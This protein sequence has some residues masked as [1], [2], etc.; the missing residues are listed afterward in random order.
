MLEED[1]L[2]D[3]WQVEAKESD[4]VEDQGIQMRDEWKASS[5]R[6]WKTQVEAGDV[7][8]IWDPISGRNVRDVQRA[9]DLGRLG[10]NCLMSLE[11]DLAVGTN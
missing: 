3:K 8:K 2:G 10:R 6:S 7:R 9:K 1:P 11:Q 4:E 5:K